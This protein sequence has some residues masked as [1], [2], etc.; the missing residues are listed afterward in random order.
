MQDMKRFVLGMVLVFII[1]VALV[2]GGKVPVEGKNKN[3]LYIS[4]YFDTFNLVPS[5]I[6]IISDALSQEGISLDT[7]YLNMKS[8]DNLSNKEL[9][10]DL[11][12]YRISKMPETYDA[13]IVADD[14]SLEFVMKYHEE[15]FTEIP[16]FFMGVNDRDVAMRCLENPLF[17]GILSEF[18]AKENIEIA[19]K[20]L[21][22]AE[23][24]V[25]LTDNSLPGI[26]DQKAFYSIK[27]E[28]PQLS[29]SNINFSELNKED[30]IKKLQAIGDGS[31][32][33]F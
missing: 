6:K 32:V 13:V 5:E 30:F 20:L 22:Q 28:Y 33:F 26:G 19:K 21:P 17:A 14:Y 3:V 15:L 2:F 12:R 7:E 11:L 25:L 1:V 31:I 18:S 4:S 9:F 8:M 23:D 27:D 24:V 29:F 10:Y 16:V